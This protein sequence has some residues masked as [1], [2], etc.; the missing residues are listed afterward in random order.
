MNPEHGAGS[1]TAVILRPNGMIGFACKHDSCATYTWTDLR[2]KIDPDHKA[3]TEITDSSES[4]D[5]PVPL[6]Q[7]ER[8]IAD[9]AFTSWR[10]PDRVTPFWVSRYCVAWVGRR[11]YSHPRS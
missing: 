6:G 4:W 10:R 8:H 9:R 11:W 1:D 3:L 2:A 5:P 7:F